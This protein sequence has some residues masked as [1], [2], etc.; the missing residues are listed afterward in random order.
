MPRTW[1]SN[2][3]KFA[4]S[5]EHHH[6]TKETN[7]MKTNQASWDR[8]VRVVLGT[9]LLYL[10]LAGVVSGAFGIILA[11]LGAVLL[12]TGVIGFCPIY[13]LLKLGTKKS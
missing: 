12:I 3:F 9:I 13:W 5:K 7:S 2:L 4:S 10:G 11:I 1:L 8:I 6:M